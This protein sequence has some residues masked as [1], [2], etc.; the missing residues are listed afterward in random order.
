MVP[1]RYE[2]IYSVLCNH[3]GEVAFV[4]DFQ[5]EA[6]WP[7]T[8]AFADSLDSDSPPDATAA[9]WTIVMTSNIVVTPHDGAMRVERV[10]TPKLSPKDEPRTV[11]MLC[12]P[13]ELFSRLVDEMRVLLDSDDRIWWAAFGGGGVP[14]SELEHT[15]IVRFLREHVLLPWILSPSHLH[16]L[17]LD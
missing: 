10:N 12:I 14:I 6:N 5:T 15:G 1:E 11:V 8:A 2:G 4:P 3:R 7:P 9:R 16:L 17:A 13:D